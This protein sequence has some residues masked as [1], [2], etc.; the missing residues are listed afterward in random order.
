[1]GASTAQGCKLWG[2]ASLDST[3]A[4]VND[5]AD[6]TTWTKIAG[7]VSVE[8]GAPIAGDIEATN[9][10]STEIQMIDDL[11]EEVAYP[12][13][14]QADL[15]EGGH[16]NLLAWQTPKTKVWFMVEVPERGVSTVY[17]V[18]IN[19]WVRN[20]RWSGSPRSVQQLSFDIMTR[21]KV[22]TSP[23]HAAEG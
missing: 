10:E 5:R 3:D 12:V 2:A 7:V 1:M 23:N 8:V 17:R 16:K 22:T 11:V 9:L 13:T 4:N 21:A 20:L 14:V 19:G 15:T 18:I 6:D